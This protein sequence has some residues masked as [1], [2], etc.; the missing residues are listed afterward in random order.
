MFRKQTG[1]VVSGKPITT[2]SQ[3]L[4]QVHRLAY[5]V[6]IFNPTGEARMI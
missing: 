3:P 1:K 5:T 6:G 4:H 2:L